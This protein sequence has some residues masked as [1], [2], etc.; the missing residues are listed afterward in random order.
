MYNLNFRLLET[1][2]NLFKI[3]GLTIALMFPLG[4]VV[5]CLLYSGTS[6]DWFSMFYR[7]WSE[8]LVE[9]CHVDIM[10][11]GGTWEV[12]K[13]FLSQECTEQK[14]VSNFFSGDRDSCVQSSK[15]VQ[16]IAKSVSVTIMCHEL[17]NTLW[18]LDLCYM[19]LRKRC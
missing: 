16:V 19:H 3:R 5:R 2:T 11:I 1:A 13:D 9:T 10:L 15:M 14:L 12:K 17:E 18:L 4:P 7:I 8:L 6:P